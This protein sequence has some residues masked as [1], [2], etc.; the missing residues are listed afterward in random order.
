M[1][2]VCRRMRGNRIA[3]LEFMNATDTQFESAA[4]EDADMRTCAGCREKTERVFL[5][6]FV[7]HPEVGL[8]YD[9]RQK[10]PGRGAWVH[11]DVDC[12]RGA[13]THG[14][15][16]RAFKQRIPSR[17]VDEVVSEMREGLSRRL[18]ES[19]QIAIRAQK[20]HLGATKTVEGFKAGE[21]GL[22]FVA[23]DAGES[24][25]RKFE[26]MAKSEDLP[27]YDVFTCEELGGVFGYEQLA[28]SAISGPKHVERIGRDVE[29]LQAIEAL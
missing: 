13:V 9:M 10:A 5:E 18:N 29:K 3:S 16:A 25:R 6:R 12:V 7:F 26:T 27:V 1:R 8:V 15:F 17:D 11:P 14:G 22:V 24:T 21:V 2:S 19:I 23:T 28:V 4:S 20:A